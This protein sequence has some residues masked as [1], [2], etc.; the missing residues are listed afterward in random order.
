[1]KNSA[2]LAAFCNQFPQIKP[3]NITVY[4]TSSG[5]AGGVLQYEFDVTVLQDDD[6]FRKYR[7]KCSLA[8]I[9]PNENW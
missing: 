8:E 4:S 6:E 3:E 1:M 7:F 5:F 2:V 9:K